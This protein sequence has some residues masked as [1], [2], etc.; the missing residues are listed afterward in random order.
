MEQEGTVTGWGDITLEKPSAEEGVWEKGSVFRR[1]S[2][3]DFRNV[4]EVWEMLFLLPS[5]AVQKD[6]LE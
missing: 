3:C 4:A 1:Q 2:Y 6:K 5:L